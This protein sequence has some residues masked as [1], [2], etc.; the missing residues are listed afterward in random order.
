[1]SF[2]NVWGVT[3]RG[4]D[5]GITVIELFTTEDLATAFRD[6]YVVRLGDPNVIYGVTRFTVWDGPMRGYQQ[7]TG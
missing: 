6:G 4:A 5:E 7:T 1:M 2:Q 3:K